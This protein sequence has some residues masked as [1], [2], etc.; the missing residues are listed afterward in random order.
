MGEESM[1]GPAEPSLWGATGNGVGPWASERGLP[2]PED[3]RYDPELLRDGDAR[4]VVDAYRYWRRDAIVADI[5]TRRHRL[6]IAIENFEND[7]NIGTVVRTANAFA[8][9]TVHIVGRRRWNRRG[10]MVTDRYQHLMHHDSTD[11]LLEYAVR[12]GLAVVAVDNVPGSVPLET[13]RLPQDCLMVFGQEGPGV[14][15][16]SKGGAVMTV[17]IA[18]FGST[19]SIN[20]GVAAGVAMHA[21]IRQHADLNRAW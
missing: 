8:V 1:D 4:N 16:A 6:H 17:S 3:P 5:D 18:Q 21:W 20:A 11:E 7:A 15:D 19:R 10:A 9:H 13:A 14:T 2:L 12:A